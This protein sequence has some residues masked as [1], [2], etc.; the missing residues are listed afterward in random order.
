VLKLELW[1]RRWKCGRCCLCCCWVV[2]VSLPRRWSA[3]SVRVGWI[4]KGTLDSVTTGGHFAYGHLMKRQ[5][6]SRKK[7]TH[8]ASTSHIQ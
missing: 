6:K 1:E 3:A 7:L 5:L 2:V 8:R 4:F